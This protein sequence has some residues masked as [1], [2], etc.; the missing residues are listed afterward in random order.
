MPATANAQAYTHE[1]TIE[2]RNN[3]LVVLISGTGPVNNYMFFLCFSRAQ[4]WQAEGSSSE[5]CPWTW[6]FANLFDNSW[7]EDFSRVI[8]W[9]SGNYDVMTTR[10]EDDNAQSWKKVS[11]GAIFTRQQEFRTYD[12]GKCWVVGRP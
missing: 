3:R 5:P 1:G 12:D 11:T 4:T 6:P 8:N 2:S 7:T 9:G 10:T